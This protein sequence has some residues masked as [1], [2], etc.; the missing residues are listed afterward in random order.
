MITSEAETVAADIRVL[1]DGLNQRLADAQRLGI[2][3]SLEHAWKGDFDAPHRTILSLNQN[4][5]V[6]VA[7]IS[8][9]ELL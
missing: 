8:R 5:R 6:R 3:V 9:T 1:V 7:E 2:S 4:S